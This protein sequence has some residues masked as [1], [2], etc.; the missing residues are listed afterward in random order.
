M[1]MPPSAADTRRDRLL[2]VLSF[3]LLPCMVGSVGCQSWVTRKKEEKHEKEIRLMREKLADP[4]RPRLAGEIA[5]PLGLTIQRF[6]TI[7]LI[8]NLPG[9]GGIVEPSQQRD[10]ILT[11]MRRHEVLDAESI[12]DSPA[13]AVAKAFV[14]VNPSHN[15]SDRLDVIV[16]CS[17]TCK[18]TDLQDGYLMPSTLREYQVLQG[19]VRNSGEKATASGDF[20]TLPASVTGEEKFNPLRGVIIG[21][22]KLLEAPKLGI[23]V[24]KDWRHVMVVGAIADSINRRFY[25]KDGTRQRQVAEGKNDWHIALEIVPKYRWDPMHYMST[26]LSIGFRETEVQIEERIHGCRKLLVSRETARK[27]AC[28]LEAIG[29]KEAIEVLLEGLMCADPEVRLHSAYSLAYLDRPECVPVLRELAIQ[30]PAFRPVCLIG[31]GVNENPS[32]REALMD[33]LQ[34]TEPEVRYGA[35]LAIRQSNPR[36]PITVGEPIGEICHVIQ[37]P[38]NSPAVV[39]SLEERKE[40]VVFGN[41]TLITLNQEFSPTPSLSVVPLPGGLIRIAKRQRDGEVL[42]S[43]V[44]ND[45]QSL[46]R[47][48]PTVEANYNDVVHMMDQLQSSQ[49]LGVPLAINP[50]PRAGRIYQ[51]DTTDTESGEEVIETVQVDSASRTASGK[52]K[53]GGI[54]LAS[55]PSFLTSKPS[56]EDAA[57]EK[58]SSKASDGSLVP[59]EGNQP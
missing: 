8:S 39:V 6:D 25:F 41:N 54:S 36:D 38:S 11:E 48:M 12:V 59:E 19:K 44:S 35:L 55:W 26:V 51:R 45:L 18:A 49:S 56:E 4:D 5:T 20:V 13:T 52:S 17:S 57:L 32:S 58:Q 30:E 14:L 1:P 43:I 31:L 40:M 16:E 53:R 28:E 33:L 42:Q 9:T 37:I 27:A 34:E 47:A 7:G 22:G 46:I 3:L 24:N 2:L 23:R 10:M 29:N 15:K 50:R 21:G